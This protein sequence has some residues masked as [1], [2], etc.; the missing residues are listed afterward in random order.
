MQRRT[1]GTLAALLA[2]AVCPVQAE[3]FRCT[4]PAGAVSYQQTECAASETARKIDVPSAYPAADPAERDR[5]FAREA[6]LDRRLEAERDR[7]NREAIAHAMQP[8]PAPQPE[9]TDVP[10]IVWAAPPIAFHRHAFAH[11]GAVRGLRRN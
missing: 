6:A 1:P 7:W 5:L 11:R 2:L 8:A 4:S 9:A 10:T 3:I